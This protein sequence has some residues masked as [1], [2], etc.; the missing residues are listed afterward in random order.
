[1]K[2][3]PFYEQVASQLKTHRELLAWY[4]YLTELYTPIE[5]YPGDKQILI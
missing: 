3:T 4:I 5:E 2:L 1:M